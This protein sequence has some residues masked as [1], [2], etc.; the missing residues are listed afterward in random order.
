MDSIDADRRLLEAIRGDDPAAFEEFVRRYGGRILGFGMRVCGEPEDAKDVA[1]ETLIQA[2]RS[3]KDV[4]EP[5]ALRSWLFRVVSNAC[6]MRRRKR[7]HE[8]QRELSLDE[9]MPRGVEDAE[10]EI[11]DARHLPEDEAAREEVREAVHVGIKKL[12]PEYRMVLLLRDIEQLSTRETADA[13]QLN[14]ST[15]KMRLHR[16]RLMLRSV[17]ADR[18]GRARAGSGEGS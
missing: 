8:P 3:L 10:I 2:Y 9:L 17:L 7:K 14:E 11:P 6:L 1:Q 16:A 5:K 4:D 12:A 18:L 15:V 13:L